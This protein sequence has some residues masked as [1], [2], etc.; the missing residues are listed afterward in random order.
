MESQDD[1]GSRASAKGQSER[2]GALGPGIYYHDMM[3]I[4]QSNHDKMCYFNIW[5]P[6]T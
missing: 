1:I 5:P 2:G 6:T 3:R 4:L